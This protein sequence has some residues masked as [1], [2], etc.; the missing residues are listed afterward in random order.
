ML[1]LRHH[2]IV[3]LRTVSHALFSRWPTAAFPPALLVVLLTGGLLL[4]CGGGAAVA[5]NDPTATQDPTLPRTNFYEIRTEY[6]RMV[7]RLFDE[8]PA[9]RDNF[10]RL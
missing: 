4:G 2:F 7:I 5:E 10:K 9:H 3:T 6:G 1:T 8:T